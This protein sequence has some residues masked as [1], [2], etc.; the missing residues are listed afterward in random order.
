MAQSEKKKGPATLGL[1][2]EK[3]GHRNEKGEKGKTCGAGGEKVENLTI[4][5]GR[6]SC[7]ES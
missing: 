7:R 5:R 3:R 4:E 6:E 2:A 1:R